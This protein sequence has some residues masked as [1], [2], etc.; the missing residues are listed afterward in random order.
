M[1]S[2]ALAVILGRSYAMDSHPNGSFP[3]NLLV[4]NGKN[5]DNLCKQMEVIFYYQDAWDIVKNGVTPISDC[6]NDEKI[7]LIRIKEV[8]LQRSFYNS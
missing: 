1:V 7:M 4:L 8:G 3:A 2:R 5:C 6:V